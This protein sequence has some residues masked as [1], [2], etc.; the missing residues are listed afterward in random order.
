M[1]RT[2]RQRFQPHLAVFIALSLGLFLATGL[3]GAAHAAVSDIYL[4]VASS[5]DTIDFST[6]DSENFSQFFTNEGA[7]APSLT[8]GGNV[9]AQIGAIYDDGLDTGNWYEMQIVIDSNGDG[10]LT[11]FD[12]S[13][14]I[15]PWNRPDNGTP[16]NPDDDP[17]SWTYTYPN[18]YPNQ[19]LAGQTT[20]PI[21][22]SDQ[23]GCI[24]N[25]P[26]DTWDQ[27][28][29]EQN[30]EADKTD[31]WWIESGQL[32]NVWWSGRDQNWNMLPNGNY[33][34]LAR[35][36]MNNDGSFENEIGESLVI[37]I[38]TASIT[39]TV[40]DAD[41]NPIY[42]AR[43]D[44]GSHLAWGEAVTKSDGTFIV[45]G[46][47]AGGTYHVNIQADGKVTGNRDV[48]LVTGETTVSI[49][50]VALSPA[51]TITGTLKLDRDADGVT[52][53]IAD[54]FQT[55]TNQWGW[56]QNDMTV[57][58]NSNNV[59]GPGWGNAE[60]RFQY[61]DE[62][63]SGDSS[64][65]FAI[66]IPPPS[67]SARYQININA[68]G[69]AASPVY[70]DVDANGGDAG[71][72][73]LTKASVLQG[74]VKLPAAISTWTHIDVQAINTEDTD[75]RY[76]GWGNI[77]P[78]QNGGSADTGTIQIDGIPAGTYNLEVR[79]MGYKT[80]TTANLEIVQGQDKTIGPLTIEEG[81][82]ISGTL[83]IQGD[84]TD[85]QRWEGDDQDPMDIWIDAWSPSAA[86]SGINVQVNRGVD[87]TVQFN[88]G[89]LSDATYEINSFISEGYE[90]VD[91]DGNAPVLAT[92]NGTATKNL[93]LKPNEGIVTGTITESG[94]VVDFSKVVV[95]AKQPWNWMPP[96]IATV[97][98]G[99]IDADT[100]QYTISG[101]GTGDYVVKA[102]VYSTWKDESGTASDPAEYDGMGTLY[103]DTG[104]GVV[105][106]RAFVQNDADNP[107]M[108]NLTF[109]KG[110][111]I[112][113]AV[114]LSQT[115]PPWHDFGDGTF[116]NGRP[117]GEPNGRKD[118]KD[119]P[120][121]SEEISMEAD[122]VGKSVK[123]IP[124]EMMFMG[125][126]DPRKGEIQPDGTYRIDGLAPGVYILTPPAGSNRI[127][128]FEST[129]QDADG[130]EGDQETHHWTTSPQMVVIGDSEVSGKN[131]VLANG[132]TVTGTLTM[133]EA[134]TVSNSQE[135]PPQGEWVGHLELGTAGQEF[136]SHGYPVFT[137]DFNGG[138]RYDF[139]FNHVANGNYLV[140]FW[141][142]RYVPGTAKFKVNNANASV[143]VTVETGANLVG[144]L[145]DA[146]TGEAV[147]GQDGVRVICEAVPWVEGSRRETRDEDQSSLSY[148]E[149]GATGNNGGSGGDNSRTNNTPGRFHLTAV[150]SGNKFVV[151]VEAEH[152]KKTGGAKNYVGRVI[153]GI[154]VPEGAT[155]DVNVGTIK[156]KE[157]TTI[158]GR[159]T[160]TDGNPIPGI[161]VVAVPSDT[162]GGS[163]ETEGVSDTN[164]YYTIYGV[165]PEIEYYDL[166]AAEKPQPFDEWGKVVPWGEKR[167]YNIQPASADVDFVLE[168][169]TASLGGTI[170][171]PDTAE[172]MGPFKGEGEEF[173]AAFILLQ[174]KGVI[175]S[176]MLDGIEALSTTGRRR[177]Y[178]DNLYHR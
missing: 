152:G 68:E 61:D 128:S 165:D 18:D 170:T 101:L 87:Q 3:P 86:W 55:F 41:G 38:E 69:Y 175:Y 145:I 12:W 127:R 64:K 153:A 56:E 120:G 58:V 148:I 109:Q 161:A 2:I 22:W 116:Q 107:T 105:T 100:G 31:S 104:V 117:G 146:D 80:Y 91:G 24:Q 137:T 122:L 52:D 6:M 66:N 123:A 156:L 30:Q 124:M 14:P 172:F 102:G 129:D 71:T 151:R 138:T 43:V 130:G 62:T 167:K 59:M 174:K 11:P 168:S 111:S 96:K 49:G 42:N 150:P 50:T 4:G 13:D 17:V 21:T 98:N 45:S 149:T 23:C 143:N 144:K 47:Q 85:L 84:T 177:N 34:V 160:D 82:K 140:R 20:D 92:V 35:V 89:G 63:Q 99:K 95:E 54:Q 163:A 132:H 79:V 93:I 81:S 125:G 73:V 119:N 94:A 57:W 112:S 70:V 78:S 147:T 164:G 48:E 83:T 60:V 126:E 25:F 27:W 40:K 114:S 36:D 9:E 121:K 67:G 131:F 10:I 32:M 159:I 15:H 29:Y 176:D 72:I 169:A 5:Q 53:E 46:L 77:D 136:M 171:I 75:D 162:H 154:D 65:S 7:T 28:F 178:D 39:G 44:A 173:P 26:W 51:V 135:G 33:K 90:L 108:V 97:A 37:R 157:G 74:T 113:G 19:A 141:T 106:H 76:W 88:L 103:S 139:T 115:D 110:Y 158:Q 8:I 118:V 142:D 134:Q 1:Q 133:P 155:G 166:F 16:E